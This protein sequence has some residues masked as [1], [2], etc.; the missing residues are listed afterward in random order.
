[1]NCNTSR[2]QKSLT[3]AIRHL[4]AIS[5]EPLHGKILHLRHLTMAMKCKAVI[6]ILN[7]ILVHY[8]QLLVW[9]GCDSTSF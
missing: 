9:E 7:E 4:L 2:L 3:V 1:M 6:R 8:V 5:M